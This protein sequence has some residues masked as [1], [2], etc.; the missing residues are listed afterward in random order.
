V[1]LVADSQTET[2]T[3]STLDSADEAMDTIKTYKNTIDILMRVMDAVSRES[4]LN[5]SFPL[6]LSAEFLTSHPGR[7][8]VWIYLSWEVALPECSVFVSAQ[9]SRGSTS[10]MLLR[11]LTC[12]NQPLGQVIDEQYIGLT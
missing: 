4:M 3:S 8:Y 6:H 5:I 9:P 10:T 11:P 12:L 1:R 7:R 2:K